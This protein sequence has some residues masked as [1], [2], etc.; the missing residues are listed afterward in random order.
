MN[1]WQVLG[2]PEDASQEDVRAAYRRLTRTHH[3]DRHANASP[4]E[5]T[6]H[7][8]RMAEVTGAWRLI[9]DPA[10]LARHRARQPATSTAEDDARTTNP[11]A[12]RPAGTSGTT[13]N[14]GVAR[15]QGFDYRAAAA[16]EFTMDDEARWDRTPP[17]RHRP[18]PSSGPAAHQSAAR[19]RRSLGRRLL[20]ALF[21][22]VVLAVFGGG[23]WIAFTDAGQAFYN[24]VVAGDTA[25]TWT[26]VATSDGSAGTLAS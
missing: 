24:K 3:P 22:V 8:Q 21:W 4:T 16:T 26:V 14:T 17:P 11:G 18:T 1:P 6:L 19:P 15:P 10:A 5:R 13:D 2:V 12:A 23:A 20:G 25:S 7:E 9:N